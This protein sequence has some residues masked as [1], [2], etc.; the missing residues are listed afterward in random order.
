MFEFFFAGPFSQWYFADFVVDGIKYCTAEQYMMAG[1]ARLFKDEQTLAKILLSR[2]PRDQKQLGREVK[3]FKVDVWN[4]HARDIVYEGNWAKFTQ[5]PGL[6]D[7]LLK[8]ED[9]LLVE[10]SPTDQVWGVGLS[11]SDGNIQNPKNWK[12]TNW[13]GEVLTRVRDDIRAGKKTTE[14][15]GWSKTI[16]LYEKEPP[17]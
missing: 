17:L 10:G 2:Y 1:K 8:T 6:R 16:F 12:G 11:C 4:A 9:R 7:I 5:N 3:N 14:N 13:L 15:F